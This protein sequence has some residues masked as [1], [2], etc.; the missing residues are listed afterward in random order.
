MLRHDGI[1]RIYDVVVPEG[2]RGVPMAV[3]LGFHGLGN[4]SHEQATVSGL[5]VRAQAEGFIAV[6]PRGSDFDGTTP[7]YFNLET[8]DG[9]SLADDVG[10]TAAILDDVEADLCV[11]RTRIYAMGLSNGGAFAATLG[12]RLSERIAAVAP[13]AAV[14]L[15]PDCDGRP[16]P[17]LITH[18]TADPVVP[19]AEADVGPRTL[20][21]IRGL[22]LGTGGNDAQLRMIAAVTATSVNSWVE[23]WAQRNGCGPATLEVADEGTDVEITTY[24]GCRADGD[25][26][27]QA[28]L[29]GG[30]DWPSSPG[31]D[32]TAHALDFFWR[33]PLPVE[34][35]G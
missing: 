30:H 23:S 28:V 3:V 13:V 32:A 18:G 27:L 8:T 12:C 25:V 35:H 26:V 15:L 34:L 10:F 7:A 14:H 11:D 33:H 9:P 1:D 2:P 24:E 21:L 6:F 17:I 22:I 4:S 20:E 29:E 16:M 5:G 19:F 31:F